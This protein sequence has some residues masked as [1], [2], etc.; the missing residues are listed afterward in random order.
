MVL[1][2]RQPG[3]ASDPAGGQP[4]A[5]RAASRTMVP[6]LADAIAELLT[7]Q[8]PGHDLYLRPTI[9]LDQG[10]YTSDPEQC[11]FG[12]FV[13]VRSAP[14]GLSPVSACV[15]SFQRVAS[16]AFPARA[17][18]GASYAMFRLARLEAHGAGYEEAILLDGQRRV[19]E[20]GG[21]SVFVVSSG[22]RVATPDLSCDILDSITRRH[23]LAILRSRLGIGVTERPVLAPELLA[24]DE[25]FL[26]GT[27][28]EIRTVSRLPGA[29][30]TLGAA[31]GSA[32]REIYLEMCRGRAEPLDRVY[33][34][35]GPPMTGVFPADEGGR[36][37]DA[38]G[39][40]GI[41]DVFD[42]SYAHFWADELG[43]R[44]LAGD[45]ARITAVAAQVGVGGP[46]RRPRGA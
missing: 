45:I 28:D 31:I 15:S 10:S 9:Y 30:P 13:S 11:T 42:A 14:S 27:L 33:V 36:A 21:A 38:G 4:A 18:S 44:R 6:P 24:A 26:A 37:E 40:G 7:W 22:G 46:A 17:K 34:H 43:G 20:T 41:R 16:E 3:R 25:V 35:H 23:A 39:A 8:Q 29:L 1:G 19:T 12:A 32:V 2:S 5:A